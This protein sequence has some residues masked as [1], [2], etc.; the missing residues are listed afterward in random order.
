MAIKFGRHIGAVLL[1]ATGILLAAVLFLF[2]RS[3]VPASLE[4]YV[5]RYGEEPISFSLRSGFYEEDLLLELNAPEPMPEGAAIY[6]SLDGTE[7]TLDSECY[8]GPVSLQRGNNVHEGERKRFETAA[9]EERTARALSEDDL[10]KPAEEVLT[11][12]LLPDEDFD[13][14]DEDDQ[15]SGESGLQSLF[16]PGGADYDPENPAAATTVFTVRARIIWQDESTQTQYGVY[17]IGRECLPF[18][19]GFIFCIDTDPAAL[20][21]YDTGILVGGREFDENLDK[22]SGNYMHHGSKWTRPCHV[23]VFDSDGMLLFNSNTGLALSGGMSRRLD[24]KSFNLS[25]GK[26]YG[27]EDGHFYMDIFKNPSEAEHAPVTSFTHLR[28][29]ARSQVPRTFRESLIGE[30]AMESGCRASVMPCPGLVF[31][32]GEFYTLAE[33]EPTFSDSLLA[34][35]FDLPDTDNIVKKKGKESSVFRRLDIT[36]LF[37]ADL[38]REE[39]RIALEKAV[40]MDDFLLEYAFNILVNNLDWPRNNVEAWKYTGEYDPL[41]PYTDGRLRFVIFDSD[42]ALNADPALEIDFGTDNLT[43]IMENKFVGRD[44]AF[45]NVMKEKSYRDRFFTIL[46]DLMNTSFRAEHVLNLMRGCYSQVE[47]EIQ[48]YYTEDYRR[49]IQENLEGAMNLVMSRNETVRADLETWFGLKPEDSYQLEL[50]AGKG[51]SV[52]WDFMNV[53]QGTSYTGSY[54]T[55]IPITFTASPAPGWRFDHW[56]VNGK[57]YLPEAETDEPGTGDKDKEGKESS[58]TSSKAELTITGN[59]EP[60][61]TCVVQAVAVR[62]EGERLIISEVSAAGKSDWFL[63]YNAGTTDI[64]LGKYCLSD[65]PGDL[66]KFRLPTEILEPGDTCR[67]NGHRNESGMALCVCNFNLAADEILTLTPDEGYGLKGDSVR[68]PRMSRASSYGRKDNG[69]TWVWFY[70]PNFD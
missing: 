1:T 57:K 26:P 48:S 37:A 69:N 3:R 60:G 17:C 61:D 38:T 34:H 21:D 24:Q 2:V 40:D 47:E 39:N 15:T 9:A 12:D 46:S 7:P 4:A 56:E 49:Q 70:D 67:I 45:P 16:F 58:H 13:E 18:R 51:V 35:R 6:Y 66:R 52:S 64:N 36:D 8:R 11:D 63:L 44:S 28:L 30:L 20:Y 42:K 25:A 43:N 62:E 29:R 10:I 19:D 22:F 41:R 54:Y 33:I 32:N 31:L 5:D 53:P 68:I 50:T 27:E 23:A 59:L 55:G 14:P 65:D